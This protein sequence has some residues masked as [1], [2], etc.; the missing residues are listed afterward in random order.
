MIS[1]QALSSLSGIS[2]QRPADICTFPEKSMNELA[3]MANNFISE[4]LYDKRGMES[5]GSRC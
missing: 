1:V 2:T 4:C 3:N 5:E